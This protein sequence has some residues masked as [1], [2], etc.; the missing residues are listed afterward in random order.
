MFYS[1][2]YV[3]EI[4]GAGPH[5]VVRFVRRELGVGAFGIKLV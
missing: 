3:D 5:G 2:S 1:V 4:A